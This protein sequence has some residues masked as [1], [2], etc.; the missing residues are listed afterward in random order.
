MN[1]YSD[2]AAPALRLE[3]ELSIYRAGELKLLM[4]S[5]VAAVAGR[6]QAQFDLS[7]VTEIDTA[8]V[9]LLL[10]ACRE[11][12]AGGLALK[13]AAASP[14][15]RSAFALLELDSHLAAA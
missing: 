5:A 1:G 8:G 12:A 3:G 10:L 14:A 2:E 15:V 13:L 11:A 9:Q 4:M 6:S 7:E